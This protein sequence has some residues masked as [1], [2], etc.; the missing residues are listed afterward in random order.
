MKRLD[1]INKRLRQTNQA[2]ECTNNA[3][4]VMFEYCQVLAKQIK[5]LPPEPQLSVFYHPSE[6]QKE[7]Y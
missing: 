3:D 2:R 5:T 7:K 1:F 4:E 6:G